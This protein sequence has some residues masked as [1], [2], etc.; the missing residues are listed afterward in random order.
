MVKPVAQAV[1]ALAGAVEAGENQRWQRQI[2]STPEPAN[3]RR[4]KEADLRQQ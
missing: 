2:I 1:L 4:A 3:E